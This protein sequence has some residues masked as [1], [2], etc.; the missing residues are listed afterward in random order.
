[1]GT[2]RTHQS[3]PWPNRTLPDSADNRSKFVNIQIENITPV[4]MKKPQTH[5]LMLWLYRT[6]GRT[7][8][9]V[10]S[11]SLDPVKMSALLSVWCKHAGALTLFTHGRREAEKK[12]GGNQRNTEMTSSR[13]LKSPDCIHCTSISCVDIG[14]SDQRGKHGSTKGLIRK[15]SPTE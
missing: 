4:A 15:V 7:R 1:M 8:H 2:T 13:P 10:S 14:K 9:K 5:M 3:N 12:P 11:L 6:P